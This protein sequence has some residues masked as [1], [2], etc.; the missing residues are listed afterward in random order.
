MRGLTLECAGGHPAWV[1]ELVSGAMRHYKSRGQSRWAAPFLTGLLASGSSSTVPTPARP[2]VGRRQWHPTG[3]GCSSAQPLVGGVAASTRKAQAC[4]LV[5]SADGRHNHQPLR[6]ARAGSYTTFQS[7][8]AAERAELLAAVTTWGS[9]IGGARLACLEKGVLV[10]DSN[11]R[12]MLSQHKSQAQ[13][14]WLSTIPVGD[15]VMSK[16]SEMGKAVASIFNN[17]DKIAF[18]TLQKPG[19]LG[20]KKYGCKSLRGGII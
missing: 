20:L 6:S 9:S 4:M 18:L 19:E 11:L 3:A 12:H 13:E 7:Q 14:E 16:S 2:A 17:P 8:T 10:S 15:A 5:A 1:A